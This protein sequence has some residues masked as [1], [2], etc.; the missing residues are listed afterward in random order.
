M[1]TPAQLRDA[2]ALLRAGSPG[3]AVAACEALLRQAADDPAV[4]QLLGVALTQAGRP[5]EGL[6]PLHR[7]AQLLPR[8]AAV[9]LAIGQAHRAL[10]NA[11]DARRAFEEVLELDRTHEAAR[12]LLAGL[13]REAGDIAAAASHYARVA[14]A[15]PAAFDAMQGFVDCVAASRDDAPATAARQPAV[16]RL[17][18]VTVG[19]CTVQPE[20]AER[21]RASLARAL[22]PA[23]V[24][25]DV[26][27]DAR[28]LAEAFNRILDRATGDVVVLC[29]DDIEVLDASIHDALADALAVADLAGV[30]GA[31]RVTGPAVLWAGHPYLHGGIAYPRDGG[32]IDA[33]L[34]SLRRGVAGGMRALDGVFV[35]LGPRARA[36]RFD[37]ATFDGFHFYD[38]DFTWRAYRQGLRLAVATGIHLAHLSEG[39]FGD[40]WQRY[41]ERFRSRHPALAGVPAGPHHAYGASFDSGAAVLAFHAR[42]DG[43]V[44]SMTVPA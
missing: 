15:R 32:R 17:G 26:I 36:L 13:L 18:A 19:F 20:R 30:V 3:A 6:A 40:S 7:A 27:D 1:A 41:A 4:L 28:S 10:G 33:T 31:E 14:L 29:H 39:D 5:A 21:A 43:A 11:I 35:A 8:A 9:H 24:T 25:F 42:L 2:A 22:A 34:F 44:S 38:L 12:V 37:A 23:A 16:D